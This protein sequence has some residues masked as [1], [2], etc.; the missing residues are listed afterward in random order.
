MGLHL[1]LLLLLG[2]SRLG[3]PVSPGPPHLQG[4]PAV[5]RLGLAPLRFLRSSGPTVLAQV[6][7]PVWLPVNATGAAAPQQ[8]GPFWGQV[9]QGVQRGL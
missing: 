2:E 6:M 7:V 5:P 1:A 9:G 4:C 8:A 3:S